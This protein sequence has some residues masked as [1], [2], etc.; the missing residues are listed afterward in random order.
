MQANHT[1]GI[2]LSDLAKS[3]RTP[4]QVVHAVRGIDV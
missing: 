3:F 1:G 4:G 2:E